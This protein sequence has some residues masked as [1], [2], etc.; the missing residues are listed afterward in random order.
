MEY[1]ALRLKVLA[2]CI[3]LQKNYILD[4]VGGKHRAYPMNKSK[5]IKPYYSP[6]IAKH[7]KSYG[8]SPYVPGYE[9][10]FTGQLDQF[11]KIYSTKYSSGSLSFIRDNIIC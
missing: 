7:A 8:M 11:V 4:I 9:F 5:V 2:Y 10:T 6:E 3:L 1:F